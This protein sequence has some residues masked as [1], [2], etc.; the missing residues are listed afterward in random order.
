M[1]PGRLWLQDQ[2]KIEKQLKRNVPPLADT[3]K[4]SYGF[5]IRCVMVSPQLS[6]ASN[7]ESMDNLFA[8]M[9]MRRILP[10][11][12]SRKT[13]SLPCH[14][15]CSF[16][17]EDVYMCGVTCKF[18]ARKLDCIR[19]GLII[20][21]YHIRPSMSVSAAEECGLQQFCCPSRGVIRPS[22]QGHDV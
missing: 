8:D 12:T 11:G 21:K 13:N 14:L 20:H 4:F 2:T 6:R 3:T 5:K 18:I 22:L 16:T 15:L 7:R 1:V 17:R 9:C 19:R 10:H